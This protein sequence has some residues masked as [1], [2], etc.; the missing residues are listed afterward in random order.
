MS[1]IDQNADLEQN[2]YNLLTKIFYLL[3]DCDR[4]FF[5]Q[6]GLSIRQFWAL[7]HLDEESGC[8]MVDLSRVLFTDKSNMTGI[9]D[10]L[11]RLNLAVRIPA[12]HDRRVI[13]IKLTPHGR[14]LRDSVNEEHEARIRTLMSVVSN[15]GLRALLDHLSAIIYSLEA[16]LGQEGTPGNTSVA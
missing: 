8:S 3:D 11:E 9:V 7:K 5:A 15:D 10:R 1:E 13:L 16:Y 2:A 14:R 12:S 4:Q 6:H